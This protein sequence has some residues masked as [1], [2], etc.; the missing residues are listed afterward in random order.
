MFFEGGLGGCIVAAM[1]ENE[2]LPSSSPARAVS[3]AGVA[4]LA[5]LDA[6]EAA[7]G[8]LSVPRAIACEMLSV[9]QSRLIELE[10]AGEVVSYLD[11]GARRVLTASIYAR[12]RR[13]VAAAHP[14]DGPQPKAKS[15]AGAF[16]RVKAP[17]RARTQAELEGL[18]KGNA[19][20]AEEA[21]LRREAKAN[22]GTRGG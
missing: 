8:H 20:R 16:K 17:P 2:T 1:E 18:R 9:G 6:R 22:S 19:K 11:G 21:R 15:P 14:L 3:P 12:L 13:L 5:A 10:L 7:D 4:M